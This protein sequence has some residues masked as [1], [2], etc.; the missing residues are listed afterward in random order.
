MDPWLIAITVYSVF[1]ITTAIPTIYAI[2]KGV[3]PHD[4]GDSFENSPNFSEEAKIK[5][6]QH[7]SRIAG[8]LG[9]WKK[10]A[11][12]FRRFHYYTLMWT[13]PASVVVPF[14]VQAISPDNTSKQFVILVT[15]HTAILFAFHKGFKVDANFKTWREG[16]SHFYDLYRRMLDR[17]MTFGETEND[18]LSAYF[19]EVE[20]LRMFIRNAEI[21]NMPTVEEA[22]K[23]LTKESVKITGKNA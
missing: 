18:Q 23:Q 8:T 9:F 12:V 19:D 10:Q 5:L 4:G 21:D 17:P 3:K 2:I 11:E 20:N 6:A 1:A 7:F 15:A 13:I 22:Q 16:E 14:L